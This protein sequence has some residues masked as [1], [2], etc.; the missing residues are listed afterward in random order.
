MGVALIS[1]R[2][3]GANLNFRVIGGTSAP[4]SPKENDIWVNT[5]TD[6]T[7]WAFSAE[8]PYEMKTTVSCAIGKTAVRLDSSGGEGYFSQTNVTEYVSIPKGTVK[9]T[10]NNCDVETADMYHAFYNSSKTLISTVLRKHGTATYEVPSGAAYVRLTM[11]DN[12]ALSA[13]PMS[14]VAT[15]GMESGFVWIKTGNASP[16]AFN[17]LK[18]NALFVY[19]NSAMQW[20]GSA[21][22]TKPSQ[23]YLGGKW[24]K[25][26]WYV[27]AFGDEEVDMT[28]SY[29][30][31]NPASTLTRY[32]DYMEL[33]TTDKGS[34]MT[35]ELVDLTEI[36]TL[37]LTVRNYVGTSSITSGYLLADNSRTGDPYSASG[38]SGR[39]AFTRVGEYSL[40]VK[41]MGL[42]YVGVGAVNATIQ[43]TELWGE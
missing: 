27:Y 24:V 40:D 35:V 33:N 9:I 13:D 32:S 30:S 29:N 34:A 15:I 3:G 16:A 11:F 23:V 18:K 12:G 31:A 10:V 1:R 22:V 36:S 28:I 19:P 7:A 41:S 2:G 14:F 20:D 37:H 17:A 38:W 8:E 4:T 6:V 39:L 43:F 42:M 25:P 21:W 5:S 26:R